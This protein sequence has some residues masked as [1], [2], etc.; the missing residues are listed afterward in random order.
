SVESYAPESSTTIE[1]KSCGVEVSAVRTTATYC[2]DR[3]RQRDRNIKANGRKRC[4]RCANPIHGLQNV[5]F[6]SD[7]CRLYHN[8]GKRTMRILKRRCANCDKI[9]LSRRAT[10]FCSSSCRATKQQDM[11]RARRPLFSHK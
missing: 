3:C 10:R 11:A 9:Y 1:C 7:L 8:N 4:K 2:S 6:C 5:S